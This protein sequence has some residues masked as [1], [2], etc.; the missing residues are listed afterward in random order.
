MQY[1]MR[2]ENILK[3]GWIYDIFICSYQINTSFTISAISVALLRSTQVKRPNG[4]AASSALAGEM[5]INIRFTAVAHPGYHSSRRILMMAYLFAGGV[6]LRN[7]WLTRDLG[8]VVQDSAAAMNDELRPKPQRP[9]AE[10]ELVRCGRKQR[11]WC[12][13]GV[14]STAANENY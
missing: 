13:R 5:E 4:F 11:R 3:I 12:R 2:W 1:D 14:I 7:A 9:D 8:K 6:H 10:W